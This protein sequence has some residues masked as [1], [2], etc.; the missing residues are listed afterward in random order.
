MPHSL[1]IRREAE[2][3]ISEA[4]A[5]YE[6]CRPNLGADFLLCLEASFSRIQRSPGHYQRVY[7]H[8]HRALIPRF[9]FGIYYTV[10]AL[11]VIVLAVL[12]A[13]RNPQHWQV[14]I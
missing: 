1:H 8:V 3:D 7:K 14:R 2:A 9:P 13:R 6:S 5:Y 12:H 4:F 10:M 11:D